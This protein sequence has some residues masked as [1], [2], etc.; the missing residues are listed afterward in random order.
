MY[1]FFSYLQDLV[2]NL[3]LTFSLFWFLRLQTEFAE[4]ADSNP[5][6][7]LC[8]LKFVYDPC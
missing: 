8:N 2:H 3:L 5:S 7:F 1:F 6:A 4:G